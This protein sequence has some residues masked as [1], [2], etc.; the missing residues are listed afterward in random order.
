MDKGQMID[1]VFEHL[2]VRTRVYEEIKRMVV[3]LYNQTGANGEDAFQDTPDEEI[4]Q[5]VNSIVTAWRRKL[6][7]DLSQEA[8]EAAYIFILG[9]PQSE[10]LCTAF[11]KFARFAEDGFQLF[12]QNFA[13]SMSNVLPL[14]ILQKI[15]DMLGDG[16]VVIEGGPGGPQ[17]NCEK[18]RKKREAE[19]EVL[20][21][22][23]SEFIN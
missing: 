22:K 3:R 19:G 4:E 12:Y 11:S 15:K 17:C 6:M 21:P 9:S 7:D 18:C 20:D 8:A 1:E 16:L 23:K 5:Y 2:D 14:G 13:S 10:F